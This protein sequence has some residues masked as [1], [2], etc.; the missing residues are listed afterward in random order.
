M[1]QAISQPNNEETVLK[2]TGITLT[3]D[4]RLV[5]FGVIHGAIYWKGVAVFILGLLLLP[6]LFMNVGFLLMFVGA[7]MLG[8]AW[9]TRRF[10][11][12]AASDKRVFVRSGVVYA[13][14]IELRYSQIESIELGMTP[15]GQI[16]N[17]GNVIISG[18]G[19]RRIMVPFISNAIDFRTRVNDILVQKEP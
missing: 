9:V 11:V 3:E 17:Y 4:E 12:L 13:D 15:I 10:L 18:T 16:F 5:T 7:V 19:Q 1:K 14:M 6:T 8:F 2:R